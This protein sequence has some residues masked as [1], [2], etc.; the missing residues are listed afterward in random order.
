[1]LSGQSECLVEVKVRTDYPSTQ[2]DKMGGAFIEFNKVERIRQFFD[3]KGINYS[4]VYYFCFFKDCLRIY[5]LSMDVYMYSWYLKSLQKNDF[6]K[7]HKINKF[8]ANL[9]EPIET[10]YY[11]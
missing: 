6:N 3:E 9:K 11:K 5:E 10:I 1:M 7:D 2:I 4:P 8:V